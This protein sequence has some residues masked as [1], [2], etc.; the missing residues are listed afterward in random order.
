M[1]KILAILIC[2]TMLVVTFVACDEPITFEDLSDATNAEQGDDSQNTDKVEESDDTKATEEDSKATEEDKKDEEKPLEPLPESSKGLWFELNEDGKGYTLMGNFDCKSSNLV[3]GQYDGLPVTAISPTFRMYDFTGSITIGHSVTELH[4]ENFV[5]ISPFLT[6]I[7]VQE[8]NPAYQGTGNCLIETATRTMILG[9]RS[10]VIPDDGSVTTIGEN[11]FRNLNGLMSIVIPDSVTVIENNAFDCCDS[12]KSVVL[13]KNLKSIGDCAFEDTEI[14]GDLVIPEGVTYV[15]KYAFLSASISSVT[16]PSTLKKIE[17]GTFCWTPLKNVTFSSGLTTIGKSAFAQCSV[18]ESIVIPE[19]VTTI[20]EDAFASCPDLKNL[21]IPN[22]LK[23]VP[24]MTTML[25][26]CR[27]VVYN[28]YC[29]GLYLGNDTNPYVC[30]IR[31]ISSSTPLTEIHPETRIVNGGLSGLKGDVF[32]PKNVHWISEEALYNRKDVTSLK[33]DKDNPVYYSEANCIIERATGTL[34][35]GIDSSVIPDDEN[36]TVVGERALSCLEATE[37]DIPK[38]YKEFRKAAFAYCSNLET[39][40]Y[41]G[42]MAE[43]KAIE[44][45]EYWNEGTKDYTVR[46]ID[47]DI[48]KADDI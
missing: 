39:I 29:G 8:G 10:S 46:C 22:S 19:G 33:V 31:R 11:A 34:V 18:L 48:A 41:A 24:T 32:I 16:I 44:K 42:T 2:I 14:S 28:E 23:K 26:S 3:V 9:S 15:G 45:G 1:K 36:I 5:G 25:M 4:A 47:G 7:T 12:L 30:L 6:N 38:N 20:E 35:L 21:S 13:S 37:I 27:K 17:E 40:N 43:W